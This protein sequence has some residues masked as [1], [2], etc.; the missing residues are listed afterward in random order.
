MRTL[1]SFGLIQEEII[2]NAIER[3]YERWDDFIGEYIWIEP[4]PVPD[5]MMKKF[6]TMKNWISN[7]LV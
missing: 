4:E 6:S 2:S 3:N 5:H 7:R 1:F